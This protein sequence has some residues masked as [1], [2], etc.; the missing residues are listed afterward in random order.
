MVR[1]SEVELGRSY[2]RHY[3]AEMAYPCVTSGAFLNFLKNI[4]FFLKPQLATPEACRWASAEIEEFQRVGTE[5]TDLNV[6]STDLQ[7]CFSFETM[8]HISEKHAPLEIRQRT[9]FRHFVCYWQSFRGMTFE[10]RLFVRQSTKHDD[11]I[12]RSSRLRPL[13]K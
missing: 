4:I 8:L 11:S 10:L 9:L 5:S 13:D 3:R 2:M 6:A 12:S 7:L 1:A